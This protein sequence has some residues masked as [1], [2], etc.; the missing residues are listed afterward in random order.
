MQGDTNARVSVAQIMKAPAV[1]QA[2]FIYFY[3]ILFAV[4]YTAVSPAF[5]FTDV[6]AGGYGF[7]P[8]LISIF[9]AFGGTSQAFWTIF[10]YPPWEAKIGRYALLQSCFLGWP[11]YF[12]MHPVNNILRR[13]GHETSFWISA[14]KSGIKSWIR[15]STN[16]FTAPD[17]P[18]LN[19]YLRSTRKSRSSNSQLNKPSLTRR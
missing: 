3:T 15:S 5:W 19:A 14:R 1:P 2:I 11:A 18:P 7:E 13:S 10:V 4:A 16:G 17:V 8:R 12:L 9:L 6:E